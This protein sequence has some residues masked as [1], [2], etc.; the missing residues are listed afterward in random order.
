MKKT[1]SKLTSW[2]KIVLILLLNA[3]VFSYAM[4]QGGFVS[5]FLFYSIL[6]LTFLSVSVVIWSNKGIIFEREISPKIAVAGESITITVTL[7]KR[8]FHPFSFIRVNDRIPEKL[9]KGFDTKNEAIFFFTFKKT[10]SYSYKLTALKRG[11][12]VFTEV[13]LVTGDLIGFS[14][15]KVNIPVKTTLFVFPHY[16]QLKNWNVNSSRGQ[17]NGSSFEE[18]FAEELSISSIR[19]YIPGD[20]MTSI[21]WKHSARN[22]KLM[23]KEFNSYQGKLSNLAFYCGN[24]TETEHTF[25]Q[26]VILSASIVNYFYKSSIPLGY[27]ELNQNLAI[28]NQGDE[29]EHYQQIYRKLALVSPTKENIDIHVNSFEPLREMVLTIVTVTLTSSLLQFVD[30]L[31]NVKCKVIICLVSNEKISHQDTKVLIEK[32]RYRGVRVYQFPGMNFS[33][34]V[35]KQVR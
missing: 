22:G 3:G 15:K 23:T 28:M 20:R 21:D 14:E 16:E 4:F 8:F 25:E 33:D 19:N 6:V 29:T 13:E 30:G 2:S 18:S 35:K 27:Y 26:A 9:Q 24:E 7:K 12:H 5:W 11:E 34:Y 31:I 17:D 10:L 32:L 1:L